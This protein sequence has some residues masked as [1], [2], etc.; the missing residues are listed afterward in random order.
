MICKYNYCRGKKTILS[1]RLTNKRK[2]QLLSTK[3]MRDVIGIIDQFTLS[4]SIN[5]RNVEQLFIV[6]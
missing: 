5:N 1:D 2:F 3:Q 4:I 6:C